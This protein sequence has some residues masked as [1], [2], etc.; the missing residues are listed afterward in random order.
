[1]S[2]TE[3]FEATGPTSGTSIRIK[4]AAKG[5]KI[6]A[7]QADLAYEAGAY[8][9]SSVGAGAMCMLSPYSIENFQIDAY[10]V[11]VNKP[12][13]A[14]YRAPGAPAR[15]PRCCSSCWPSA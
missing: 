5:D 2:R 6:T 4:M 1:M 8:P 15:L 7:V 11:V 10:D 12:K 9:G 13:S 3:V 14:A